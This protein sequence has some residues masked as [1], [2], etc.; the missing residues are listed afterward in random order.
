MVDH[1]AGPEPKNKKNNFSGFSK[2]QKYIKS[3][4]TVPYSIRRITVQIQLISVCTLCV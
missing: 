2:F 3:P 4:R 1:A